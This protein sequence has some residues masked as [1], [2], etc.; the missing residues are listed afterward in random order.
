MKSKFFFFAA[1]AMVMATGCA[2]TFD[3]GNDPAHG[4]QDEIRFSSYVNVMTKSGTKATEVFDTGDGFVVIGGYEIRPIASVLFAYVGNVFSTTRVFNV[5]TAAEPVWTSK[6]IPSDV[7]E[8]VYE[9]FIES[10]V[11]TREMIEEV[12]EFCFNSNFKASWPLATAFEGE[13]LLAAFDAME[14]M[15]WAE[16]HKYW[17]YN[18]GGL[19]YKFMALSPASLIYDAALV[20]NGNGP[21]LKPHRNLYMDGE[22]DPLYAYTSVPKED[23][24][25]DVELEFSHLGAK[26]EFKINNACADDIDVYS[27]ALGGTI[28]K[29][30]RLTSSSISSFSLNVPDAGFQSSEPKYHFY[31]PYI[32]EEIAAAME[33]KYEVEPGYIQNSGFDV[34]TVPGTIPAGTSMPTSFVVCP[35]SFDPDLNFVMLAYT[36]GDDPMY[37]VEI[38]LSEFKFGG[39]QLTQWEAGYKYTYNITIDHD[40]IN[41]RVSIDDWLNGGEDTVV[42]AGE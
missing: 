12:V 15:R 29:E 14:N 41:F 24:G 17:N 38:P 19:P 11:C 25:K 33:D 1:V 26:L 39:D 16:V 37:T 31:I 21:S 5:G 36:L 23:F 28:S 20:L 30:A 42:V 32:T 7:L 3:G 18:N 2:K 6:E 22:L 35:Q 34:Y 4:D 40:E 10:E 27:A 9:Q 13:N 8:T